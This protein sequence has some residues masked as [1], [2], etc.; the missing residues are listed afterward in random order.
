MRRMSWFDEKDDI[1]TVLDHL[2]DKVP[3]SIAEDA[4]REL[5]DRGW[6]NDQIQ[7]EEWDRTN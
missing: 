4:K 6:T 7:K 1:K 2:G 3:H 5:R